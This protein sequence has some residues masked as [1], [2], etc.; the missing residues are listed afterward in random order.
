MGEG[1]SA[2]RDRHD[3]HPERLAGGDQ[4]VDGFHRGILSRSDGK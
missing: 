3:G 1:R 4:P 2:L